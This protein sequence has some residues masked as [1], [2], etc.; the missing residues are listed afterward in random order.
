MLDNVFA[1]WQLDMRNG[2]RAHTAPSHL[3]PR[4]LRGPTDSD[5]PSTALPGDFAARKAGV[6]A[7]KHDHVEHRNAREVIHLSSFAFFFFSLA[8]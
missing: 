4:A 7:R 1:V 5:M 8:Q 2:Y 3:A 6:A